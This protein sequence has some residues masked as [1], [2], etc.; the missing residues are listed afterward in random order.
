MPMATAGVARLFRSP[1]WDAKENLGEAF[2][3]AVARYREH[4]PA[5]VA[6]EAA[7]AAMPELARAPSFPQ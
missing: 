7:E 2:E 4:R 1:A 5:V 6:A 3:R